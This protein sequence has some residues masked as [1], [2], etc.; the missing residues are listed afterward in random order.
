MAGWQAL[1]PMIAGPGGHVVAIVLGALFGSFANVCIYRLPPTDEFPDGRS[2]ALPASHCP[3][4]KAPIAWYD[5]VP[6]LSY[7]W[8]RGRCR[9]CA[10]GF[11]PRYLLVEGAT[12]LLFGAVFHYH[13]VVMADAGPLEVRLIRCAIAAAFAFVL[14]VITFIDLDHKLI[15]DKITYPAIP[16]FYLAGLALP[17]RRWTDG[18]IGALVG[19]LVI[20]GVSDGYF[21]LTGRR[22]LGYGDGKLL[23]IVGAWLGWH[24]VVVALFLGSL[25][26]TVV[27]LGILAIGGRGALGAAPVEPASEP[28]L[29]P[30]GATSTDSD[31]TSAGD[32]AGAPAPASEDDAPASIR[33]VEIP[34]GP[35]LAA[36]ALGYMFVE[37]A[38]RVGLRLLYS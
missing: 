37:P 25:I 2:V 18:L 24:A 34:F 23:A 31:P 33:H 26:G 32:A 9:R 36:G 8:L 22:G 30:P 17:E 7:L 21:L 12:A 38:L 15:L 35:F 27:T 5:N 14:V 19:Y 20:R 11:S 29:E 16:L 4:C 6:I 13:L 28:G 3:A 1:E 10:A